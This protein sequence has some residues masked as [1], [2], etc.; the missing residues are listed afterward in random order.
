MNNISLCYHRIGLV[1]TQVTITLTIDV[2]YRPMGSAFFA[3]GYNALSSG[4]GWNNLNELHVL[5]LTSITNADCVSRLP[6]FSS[7]IYDHT[8]C[9]L[10]APGN[11]I[12]EE[13]NPLVANGQ[14]HGVS[15]WDA[16][17]DGST[18]SMHE[19]IFHFRS[20]IES[21]IS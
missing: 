1:Q 4:W 11:S 12:C 9:V 13:G 2:Q 17:C 16:Q 14:I 3:P 18:P 5:V 8:L 7:V 21:I 20:W 15:A 10:S 19:R 6:E